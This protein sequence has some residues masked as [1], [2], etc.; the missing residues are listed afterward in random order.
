MIGKLVDGVVCLVMMRSVEV[1][2]ATSR[3]TFRS[4]VQSLASRMLVDLQLRWP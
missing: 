3:V 2:W 4:H 1:E